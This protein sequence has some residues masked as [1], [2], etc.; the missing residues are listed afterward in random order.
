MRRPTITDGVESVGEHQVR[1]RIL[2]ADDNE[3]IRRIL[4][5]ILHQ[6]HF[7]IIEARDGQEALELLER[8]PVDLAVLDVMMPRLD[9]LTLCRQ[10]REHPRL[11]T[12]P[13]IICTSMDRKSDVLRAMAAGADDYIIKPF[14]RELTVARIRRALVHKERRTEARPG[15]RERRALPRVRVEWP[16]TLNPGDSGIP[17]GRH[18][19]QDISLQGAG[20]DIPADDR[21]VQPQE[22][23][24]LLMEVDAATHLEARGR[25]VHVTDEK[26][27]PSLRR[28][29]ITFIDLPAAVRNKIE[30][31][32]Y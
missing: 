3:S 21:R 12:L 8:E 5:L 30:Q 1:R 4:A 28:V 17:P 26:S 32:T 18:R 15:T 7:E 29:G 11:S 20:V 25:I 31:F 27:P 24:T 9:G 13:V 23:V 16:V 10:I 19:I 2:L 22:T 14:K 6:S